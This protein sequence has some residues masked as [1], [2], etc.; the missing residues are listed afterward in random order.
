MAA[1]QPTDEWCAGR[2]DEWVIQWLIHYRD[3]LRVCHR[4]GFR[5]SSGTRSVV[6]QLKREMRRRGLCAKAAR[7]S[8]AINQG[9]A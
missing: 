8:K 4:S 9:A 7:P 1:E 2:S 5:A 3:W 6:R